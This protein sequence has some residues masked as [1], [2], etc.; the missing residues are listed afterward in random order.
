MDVNLWYGISRRLML[1]F[2]M[3]ITLGRLTYEDPRPPLTGLGDFNI[4]AKYACLVREGYGWQGQVTLVGGIKFPTSSRPTLNHI[5]L[6]GTKSLDFITGLSAYYKTLHWYYHAVVGY[7]T[8]TKAREVLWGNT[9]EF[10]GSL[11]YAPYF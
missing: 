6:T 2:Q 8:N 3:P 10:G 7:R 5:D 9:F 4:K 11:R 1:W